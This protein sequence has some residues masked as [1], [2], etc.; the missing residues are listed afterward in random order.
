M[1]ISGSVIV[2]LSAASVCAAGTAAALPGL[3]VL[4]PGGRFRV[5]TVHPQDTA[6]LGPVDLKGAA[7]TVTQT[8]VRED[9][10]GEFHHTWSGDATCVPG[11]A[12]RFTFVTI[13][14]VNARTPSAVTPPLLAVRSG[15]PGAGQSPTAAKLGTCPSGMMMIP[16]GSFQMGEK[17]GKNTDRQPAH[18]VTLSPYCLDRT[19]VTV[20]AYQTCVASGTCTAPAPPEKDSSNQMAVCN[21]SLSGSEQQPV[22][23]VDVAQAAAFCHSRGGRLPTEAEWEFGARG[24]DSR[25]YPWGNQ[26]PN[27]KRLAWDG[28]VMH[29]VAVGSHPSGA[30]PFG[31]EDMAGN[32]HEWTSDRYGP[33]APDA[34]TNPSGAA[35]GDERVARGGGWETSGAFA[36]AATYRGQFGP[37]TRR[38]DLG[39]RCANGSQVASA[40]PAVP[41][42]STAVAPVALVPEPPKP[43]AVKYGPGNS[44]TDRAAPVTGGLL[45]LPPGTRFRVVGVNPVDAKNLPSAAKLQGADCTSGAYMFRS[46]NEYTWTGVADCS[47]G[48]P[49]SFTLVVIDLPAARAA[50]APAP[51]VAAAI[52]GAAQAKSPPLKPSWFVGNAIPDGQRFRV[53][54]FGISDRFMG[55]LPASFAGQICTAKGEMVMIEPGYFTGGVVCNGKED[56]FALVAVEFVK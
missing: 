41:T 4:D 7:C 45:A 47:P 27:A 37:T 30:S 55:R 13:D 32:V 1:K 15:E 36:V 42:A 9:S 51:V 29:P 11:G 48:G 40:T 17:R 16:G 21:S 14:L 56:F 3:V 8:F 44:M 53:A 19:E 35:A 38:D 33:Y 25:T 54:E 10:P 23:C 43:V 34:V 2:G 28:Q 5:I 50:N 24:R 22:N 52:P 49:R 18:A 46:S 12:R 39:F 31:L 26:P 6:N 20:A